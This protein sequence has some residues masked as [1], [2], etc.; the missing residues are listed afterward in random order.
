VEQTPQPQGSAAVE[1]EQRSGAPA[2]QPRRTRWIR[3]H[4]AQ[5]LRQWGAQ[6]GGFLLAVIL[7]TELLAAASLWRVLPVAARPLAAARMA[8]GAPATPTNPTPAPTSTPPLDL[9]GYVDPFVGTGIGGQ[10]WGINAAAGNTFPG[11]TLPFGMT[12]FSPDTTGGPTRVGGYGYSDSLMRGFSLTHLSGAGCPIFG[13]IPFMPTTGAPSGAFDS[14]SFSHASEA[15]E[16]G[17]Y[18]VRLGNGATV[19]LT[20]TTRTGFA[21]VQ[22]PAGATGSLALETGRDLRG[23]QAAHTQIVSPTEVTGSV[24]SGPFCAYLH[25]TYTVYF[26]AQVSAP[27]SSFGAWQGGAQPGARSAAGGGSGVYL[28]FAPSASQ[29]VLLKVG[30]SYVSVANARANLAAENPGWNFDQTR[31][32]AHATWNTLLNR[33]QVTGG[34]AT[35]E[36]IFYTALYHA[37]LVPNT[38]SDANGQYPGFDGKTHTAAGFV[39]YANFSGW[40]IYRSEVPLLALIAPQQTSDMM[41]SLVEDG[42]QADGLPRWPLANS[43]TGIMIGDSPAAILAEGE[44]FGADGFDAAAA[45]RLAVAGATQ[46][47]IGAGASVER[48]GLHAYLRL[49][50]VPPHMGAWVPVSTSLEYYSDDFAIACLARDLGQPALVR[51]F[52]ARAADW[53]AIFNPASG[54]PQPRDADG[55]FA[56]F[57]P[58]DSDI[59]VE[60]DAAQYRWMVPFDGAGLVALQGGAQATRT[61]LDAF[62]S[63]LNAGP[64]APYAFMGNEPS[65]G[66]PWMY[67]FVGA[68]TSAQATVRRIETQMYK[69]SPDGLAGN[70]DLGEMSSWYVW[71]ALGMYPLLPGQPGFVL[72]SPLFPQVALTIGS[73]VT[74]IVAPAAAPNA[75]YVQAMTIDGAPTSQLWLPLTTLKSA[76]T[77]AFTLSASAQ[78]AWA[79]APADAPPSLADDLWLAEGSVNAG[80]ARR[81]P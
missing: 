28:R 63:Q 65:F 55:D 32:A 39:Q 67:D 13:D 19:E 35:N 41:Q 25:T 71:A 80:D 24:S 17:Y 6:A 5:W 36:R 22:F 1:V 23:A 54:L 81:E 26:D 56:A 53:S 4:T 14:S 79:T 62:F 18:R 37:L 47:G 57:D 49:G 8:E 44:D 42:E 30:I 58:T 69:D 43:E 74:R 38:F 15:A 70:D 2:S 34:S 20:A 9:T 11:A 66:A 10:S 46:P 27:A 72:G 77:V 64:S 3:S 61:R 68:P 21:R 73:H 29:T 33:I 7:L 48:P 78:S 52:T 45:L 76:T 50:Y 60:G 59:Y 31:A 16:P 75:P 40:D 51:Q 12:Q